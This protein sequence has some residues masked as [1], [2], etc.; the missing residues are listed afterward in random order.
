MNGHEEWRPFG[1]DDVT[2]AAWCHYCFEP[3]EAALARDDG[4]TPLNAQRDP[5]GAARFRQR[6]AAAG[7]EPPDAR[8]WHQW[9][10]TAAEAGRWSRTGFD[11]ASASMWRTMGFSPNQTPL[12][13]GRN[14]RTVDR[15]HLQAAEGLE[16]QASLKESQP[17]E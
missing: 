9:N 6:W 11:L 5:K 1:F 8:R 15:A 3:L 4:F 10:F 13:E 12:A 16:E 7:F 17:S 14:A 2:A